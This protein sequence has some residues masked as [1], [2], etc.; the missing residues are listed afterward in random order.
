MGQ[1]LVE[2]LVPALEK[3]EWPAATGLTQAG[4]LNYGVG[5]ERA[6]DYKGDPKALAAA[7]RVFQTGD[8]LP[9][10]YAGV[11]YTLLTAARETDGSY[12]QASLDAVLQW[13]E[14]AQALAPD[15]V[16][17]NF[18]EALVYVYGR[19]FREARLVL[20]Y[21]AGQEADSY[22]V[23]SAEA[24][25]WQRQGQLEEAVKGY[26]QAMTRAATVP[27]RLLMRRR[28]GDCYFENGRL[29]E[30]QAIY[31]EMVML[32]KQNPWLWHHLSLIHYRREEYQEAARCNAKALTIMDFPAARQMETAIKKK[33]EPGVWGRLF[34]R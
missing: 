25:F 19:R 10:A 1:Q 22:Y 34:G 4:R 3:M 11:A 14:K 26:E 33:L 5:L 9:Y 6:D 12:S 28:L 8:S 30:A 18:I 32:D 20:D 21:L 17:I 29:D 16:E 13:L 7:L 2:K 31:Q 15:Q 24:L 27:Q 23:A